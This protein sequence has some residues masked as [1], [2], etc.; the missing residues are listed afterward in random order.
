MQATALRQ[1]HFMVTTAIIRIFGNLLY[2][3]NQSKRRD[4]MDNVAGNIKVRRSLPAVFSAICE[5]MPKIDIKKTAV[6]LC[7]F[8]A[9]LAA[10]AV[11]LNMKHVKIV[12]PDKTANLITFKAS[13]SD[14]LNSAGIIPSENDK[15]LLS[16]NDDNN[17]TIK[18][19]PAFKVTVTADNQI[20][21][22]MTADGTVADILKQAN[23]KL[24]PEDILNMPKD[25]KV[26]PNDNIVVSRVTYET[27]V[28]YVSVPFKT[29]TQTTINLKKGVQKVIQEGKEGQ[30]AITKRIKLVNG[31]AVQEE[32]IGESVVTQPVNKKILIGTASSTPVSNVV[33]P[34]SLK[35]D[36]KG[37]P[38]HYSHCYKGK[39]TA[40]YAKPG[41]K[42]S[43]GRTVK[44]GYVAV[45]PSKIPYGSKLY[46][47]TPDGSYVYGYAIAADT[48]AFVH[49]GSG[50]IADLFMPSREA[51]R[52]FGARTVLIYVLN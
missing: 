19:L 32:I 21:T 25:A 42:T 13:V 22:L 26:K 34:S 24:G 4:T 11:M 23:I 36:K 51:C 41:T 27:K 37:V 39:A 7:P 45:D 17:V 9:A 8:G 10:G 38:L 49:N 2:Q 48:G 6:M 16:V 18:V 47:M 46:I 14:I 3:R 52:K 1:F 30:N 12:T 35:L 50:I 40:Y 28:S 43:T 20:K 33:S 5:A 15:I 29:E 31:K 44:V